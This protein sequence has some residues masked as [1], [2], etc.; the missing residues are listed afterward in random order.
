M[1]PSGHG[2]RALVELSPGMELRQNDLSRRDPFGWVNIDR[3]TP[4]VVG[5]RNAVV[6]VDL[7]GDLVAV[8]TLCF[9]D[10]ASNRPIRAPET[11]RRAFET[12]TETP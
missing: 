6:D 1:E 11:V 2:V 4:T 3:N 7:D 9:V 5:H 8:T 12:P 10:R